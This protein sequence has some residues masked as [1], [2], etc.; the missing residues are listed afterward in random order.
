MGAFLFDP[1]NQCY[2]SQLRDSF[3]SVKY[4]D[5]CI[6]GNFAVSGRTMLKTGDYPIWNEQYFKDALH[7]APN[8]LFIMLGTNDS[9]FYNWDAH[10]DEFY[11]DYMSMIDTF[12]KRN[13]YVKFIL[14][15]PP[16]AF[17][18][19]YD[20][21]DS[22]IVN[23]II[24]L[25]DSVAKTTGADTLDLR[26]PFLGSSS[27]FPDGIHPNIVGAHIIAELDFDKLLRSTLVHKVNTNLTF[28]TSFKTSNAIV[29]DNDSVNLSWTTA[30]ADS[31][32]I[33]GKKVD[34][35]GSK[36][37]K[38]KTTTVYTL[39]AIGKYSRD[40]MQLTQTFYNPVLVRISI[41]PKTKTMSINDSVNYYITYI[42]QYGKYIT[43]ANFNVSWKIVTGSGSFKHVSS[44]MATFFPE[45]SGTATIQAKVDTVMSNTVNVTINQNVNITQAERV[46]KKINL[47]PNP[48]NDILNI[49]LLVSKPS[50][51]NIK[52]YNLK[53]ALL[54]EN[55]QYLPSQ[56]K[57]TIQ[58]KI[59]GLA[60]GIY[61]YQINCS[62]NQ[63]N[64][65]FKILKK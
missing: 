1:V 55:N 64:G 43:N 27:L 5:T 48:A 50:Q 38:G 12:K 32:F 41:S 24:P 3:L 20:I 10:K 34:L 26:Q 8:I 56:G 61:L 16:P 44:T 53:G 52:I 33:N 46:D 28:V 13:P 37:F 57:R 51:I 21:R 22:V 18:V 19:N 54:I 39:L 42:D 29:K 62:G 47:Y 63:Y 31:A 6:V 7:F 36:Y 9:K 60:N 40:S 35:N 58:L 49:E 15:L 65:K 2:P 11:G 23:G 59:N 17:I 4:G 25:I 45:T 30:N 14:C